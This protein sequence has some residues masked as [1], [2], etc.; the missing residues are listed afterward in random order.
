MASTQDIFNGLF[1]PQGLHQQR[2]QVDSQLTL[3]KEEFDARTLQYGKAFFDFSLSRSNKVSLI[4][5]GRITPGG[6]KTKTPLQ[7]IKQRLA[8]EQKQFA[9]K[10]PKP[11]QTCLVIGSSPNFVSTDKDPLREHKLRV[12]LVPQHMTQVKD[13]TSKVDSQRETLELVKR[14]ISSAKPVKRRIAVK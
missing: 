1:A 3:D 14:N 11:E 4:K 13:I 2:F 6:N 8:R 12:N 9:T 5:P 7:L 10:M